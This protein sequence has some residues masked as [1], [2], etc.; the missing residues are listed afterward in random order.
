MEMNVEKNIEKIYKPMS[1]FSG[2]SGFLPR[3]TAAYYPVQNDG[4]SLIGKIPDIQYFNDG[5]GKLIHQDRREVNST[6]EW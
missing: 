1:F 3:L 5:L 6:D 2:D 4:N